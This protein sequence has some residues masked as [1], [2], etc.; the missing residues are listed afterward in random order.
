MIDDHIVSNVCQM[1]PM[2]EELQAAF[3]AICDLEKIVLK[4]PKN[5]LKQ[6]HAQFKRLSI[7]AKYFYG[8]DPTTKEIEDELNSQQFPNFVPCGVDAYHVSNIKDI[9]LPGANPVTPVIDLTPPPENTSEVQMVNYPIISSVQ[10]SLID[11]DPQLLSLIERIK[12]QKE[13]GIELIYFQDPLYLSVICISLRDCEYLIDVSEV[14]KALQILTP[15]FSDRKI[16]KVFFNTARTCHLLHQF[17]VAHISNVFCIYTAACALRLQPS[18]E[19]L[20][21][22][23][24]QRLGEDWIPDGPQRI[25]KPQVVPNKNE[26]RLTKIVMDIEYTANDDWRARPISL[27]QMRIARQ[28]MHYLLYLYDSLRLKLKEDTPTSLNDVFLISQQKASMDWS[29]YKYHITCPNSTLLS[30]IY[31]QPLPYTTLF[32]TIMSLKLTNREILSDPIILSI[33]LDAP[34]TED[35]LKRSIEV[36]N[37]P[38]QIM[39]A[40][41]QKMIPLSL[42]HSIYNASVKVSNSGNRSNPSNQLQQKP[43][44]L[45]ET[46]VELGWVQSMDNQHSPKRRPADFCLETT[47]SPRFIKSAS[48]CQNSPGAALRYLRDPDQPTSVSLQIEGIPR[49]E[50]RIYQLANN[51]RMIQKLQG[52]TKAKLPSGKDEPVAEETP[53]E[54]LHDLVSIGYIDDEEAKIIK[55]KMAVPKP[56]RTGQ[57]RARSSDSKPTQPQRRTAP[58][59][60][61]PRP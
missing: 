8:R 35:A 24:R 28:K 15:I 5:D 45:E 59:Y 56:Q 25:S 57:K 19:E 16:T 60:K 13:V 51:V 42:Q 17:G 11:E 38:R 34:T 22:E 46:I 43:K 9:S 61:R 27:A 6:F 18:L 54:V 23:F 29:D 7:L 47:I 12:K 49:T 44:T 14:P 3:S 37:P 40:Q 39:F 2:M 36:A 20:T 33:S 21:S 31:Q 50:A 41:K 52:K 26:N 30:S 58:Q 4:N 53:S 10:F 48:C 1:S 32:K 55:D